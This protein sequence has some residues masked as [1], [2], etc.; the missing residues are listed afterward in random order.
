[1]DQAA[2]KVALERYKEI[3]LYLINNADHSCMEDISEVPAASA[4]VPTKREAQPVVE[5]VHV[6]TSSEEFTKL[7]DILVAATKISKDLVKPGTHLISLGVDSITAIQ[8]AGKYRRLGVRLR[9]EDILR[10]RTVS[11]VLRKIQSSQS[12]PSSTTAD[13]PTPIEANTSVAIP[14]SEA[15]SIRARFDDESQ[16][17]IDEI[18]VVSPGIKWLIGAWQKSDRTRFQHAFAYLLPT[19]VNTEK[20][21][22]AW[23]SLIQRHA[24]LRSTIATA[25]ESDEPRLVVFKPEPGLLASMWE[26]IMLEDASSSKDEIEAFMKQRVSSPPDLKKPVTRATLINVRE[27]KYVVIYM[28]HFQYDAWSLQLLADDLTKLYASEEPPSSNTLIPW[29]SATSPNE[30]ILAEQKAYWDSAFSSSVRPSYFPALNKDVSSSTRFV[31]TNPSA[32]TDASKLQERARS[33]GL[34]PNA[35]FLAAWSKLQSEFSSSTDSVFGLWH[36]GRSATFDQVERLALPCMNV[37]PLYVGKSGEETVL[38][39]AHQ[40]QDDLRARTPAVEQTDLV[41][42]DEW[43][44]GEGKALHNVYVNIVKVAPDVEGAE[45]SRP[46]LSPVEVSVFALELYPGN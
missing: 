37:L 25:P 10:S 32:I 36:S 34:S 46:L 22:T 33:E 45:S 14:V 20:L 21:R 26:E 43:V 42:L 3:L 2:L 16:A 12:S 5:E 44:R 9:A 31:H 40:I 17:M 41:K 1:M 11:D 7:R 23:I 6:D 15:S 8:I 38:D 24:I 27:S 39:L 4:P 19:D 35:I 29:L 13:Q 28:N 30:T 18:T